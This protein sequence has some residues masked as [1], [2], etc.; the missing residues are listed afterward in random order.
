VP[1]PALLSLLFLAQA[2]PV[3]GPEQFFVGR[4]TSTG[5]ATILMRGSH[6][7]RDRGR[8]RIERGNVLIL[9]QV[10]EEQGQPPRRRTWRLVRTADNRITGA[11]SDATGPVTGN[12]RGNVIHLS[13]R[14]MEGTS[15]EQW[16]ALDPGRRTARNRM[17]Y[18]R[19]GVT[20]AT[21]E[22]VIRRLD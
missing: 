8:G 18:S 14:S 7:V 4:T 2:H 6:I 15:V 9:E 21:V 22:T 5:T 10:V 13:Y 12:V 16:I 19:M 20:V 11:I 17:V 1:A 3:R